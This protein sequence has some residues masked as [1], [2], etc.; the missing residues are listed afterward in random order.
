[1]KLIQ[2]DPRHKVQSLGRW[3]TSQPMREA[4]AVA[5]A[6][7]ASGR[8]WQIAGKAI[9]DLAMTI[10]Q[11]EQKAQIEDAN[12]K[13]AQSALDWE[14]TKGS[15]SS[16]TNS[17]VDNT[18]EVSERFRAD[19]NI[20]SYAVKNELWMRDSKENIMELAKGISSEGVR[21]KW[22]KDQMLNARETYTK[23]SL[24]AVKEQEAYVRQTQQY[25]I[26]T[27]AQQQDWDSALVT[28]E[29]SNF[30]DIEKKQAT[31]KVNKLRETSAYNEASM[32]GDITAMN[33][34]LYEL[35]SDDYE[36]NLN[37]KERAAQASF[38]E[39]KVEAVEADIKAARAEKYDR[40]VS[41]LT[42]AASQGQADERVIE[43]LYSKNVITGAQR[44]RFLINNASAHARSVGERNVVAEVAERRAN[45]QLFDPKDDKKEWNAWYTAQGLDDRNPEDRKKAIEIM[46]IDKMMP[47]STMSFFRSHSRSRNP[48]IITDM[49]SYANDIQVHAPQAYNLLDDKDKQFIEMFRFEAEAGQVDKE[50][51]AMVHKAMDVDST[52]RKM[53]ETEYSVAI[54]DTP[55]A[56]RIDDF[57][58]ENYDTAFTSQPKASE[59]LKRDYDNVFRLNF[60]ATGNE[61]VAQ[62]L[63][64]EKLM[65][66]EY[67]FGITS[68]GGEKRL[69]KFAPEMEGYPDE[70]EDWPEVDFKRYA[71]GHG[72]RPEDVTFLPD[73]ITKQRARNDETLDYVVVDSL[74]GIRITNADGTVLRW[75][76]KQRFYMF[77]RE[78]AV[79]NKHELQAQREA[80]APINPIIR[81]MQKPGGD[82]K[83]WYE[84]RAEER[85]SPISDFFK[86]IDPFYKEAE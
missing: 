19:D 82:K 64:E 2:T 17:E 32:N 4:N 9:S 73:H 15:K 49:V 51:I 21:Q 81:E 76:P 34:Y 57:I 35:K 25:Q 69:T 61:D 70:Y 39:R 79:R 27:F 24:Q 71:E 20:P 86:S 22:I 12:F 28:I 77:N 52:T 62:K 45:G 18:I 16:F 58:D 46:A 56:K 74:T 65:S 3:D 6:K 68:A 40:V 84:K 37:A 42:V 14:R 66:R 11:T 30:S 63:T 29:Q 75:N 26:E 38:L 80:S 43:D 47:E 59:F 72:F 44:A 10:Y 33:K 85:G 54:K 83:G 67:A 7:I 78:Q 5:Q 60:M 31:D 48:E 50:T 23:Y 8:N 41:D 55:I 13:R 53:R 36:G 1:M